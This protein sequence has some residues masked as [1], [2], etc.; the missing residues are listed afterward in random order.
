MGEILSVGDEQGRSMPKGQ[1]DKDTEAEK[2]TVGLGVVS[3]FNLRM[4]S[5]RRG[6][7]AWWEPVPEVLEATWDAFDK[8][9]GGAHGS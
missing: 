2:S 1:Q 8:Q 7:R 9:E 4:T 6:W 3:S 5:K